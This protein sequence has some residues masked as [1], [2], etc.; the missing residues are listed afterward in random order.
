MTSLQ[1]HLP[2][3][4]VAALGAAPTPTRAAG[5]SQAERVAEL[6]LAARA[7]ERP[8]D[9]TP[10]D[11]AALGSVV[12]PAVVEIVETR[13][14][15]SPGD[16]RTEVGL[17]SDEERR[18]LAALGRL[19]HEGVVGHLAEL[20]AG[21]TAPERRRAA[22]AI[23]GEVGLGPDL[24]L[25]AR[26]AGGSE[27]GPSVVDR[28]QFG[29][30]LDRILGRDPGGV[31]H[32]E[33]AF[34]AAHDA[35]L[36]AL[37]SAVAEHGGGD[38]LGVLAG[39]L[40]QHPALDPLLLV[41]VGRVGAT[42]APPFHDEVLRRVRGYLNG[43]DYE[44]ILIATHTVG[45]LDDAGSVPELLRLLD[46]P[47][48]AVPKKAVET[49]QALTGERIGLNPSRWNAWFEAEQEWWAKEAS[50][51]LSRIVHG[52]PAEATDLLMRVARH[53]LYRHEVARSVCD[54]LKRPE[55]DLVY[56][57]CSTLGYLKSWT[58]LPELHACLEDRAPKVREAAAR[59]I[60]VITGMR[61]GPELTALLAQRG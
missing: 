14:F 37:V 1:L 19:P 39:R 42:L 30:S 24:P 16:E 36:H 34:D 9:R 6:L 54:A 18:L 25:L 57:A 32:A 20:T 26:V 12:V 3:L 58:V 61:P 59:A 15:P 17:R 4:L 44:L 49:L 38:G 29:T 50:Q 8:P 21:E 56:L 33:L 35:L 22:L 51:Q 53:R 5:T 60:Q 43:R 13:S 2:F 40:G 10:D 47:M 28:A 55:P 23:L 41:H 11:V 52:P 45:Q 31:A 27:A 48:P 46:D 7:G